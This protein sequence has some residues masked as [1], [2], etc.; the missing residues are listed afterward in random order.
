MIKSH[1]WEDGILLFTIELESGKTFEESFAMIK[2]DRPIETALYI[3]EEVV[4]KRRGGRYETWAKKILRRTK[5]VIRRMNNYY[6][7][8]R[9]RRIDKIKSI[10]MRRISKNRRNK[11]MKIRE[12]FGIEVPRN[13]RHA[14][15]LDAKNKNSLWAEAISKEMSALEKAKV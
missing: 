1:R 7:I 8:D 2:K 13:V 3:R 4:E 9:I 11:K 5:R 12:K 6:N 10:K 14:L 15:L